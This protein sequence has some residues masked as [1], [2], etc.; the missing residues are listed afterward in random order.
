MLQVRALT[1]EDFAAV[2]ADP[3]QLSLFAPL[4]ADARPV[5]TVVSDPQS[6]HPRD[7]TG[8]PGGEQTRR[9]PI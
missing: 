9:A 7:A 3:E 8:E 4:L 6:E 1:P 2:F 5:L